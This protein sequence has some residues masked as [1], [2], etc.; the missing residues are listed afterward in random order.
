MKMHARDY[1]LGCGSLLTEPF[2]F[3][4]E[5]ERPQLRG[6]A[7]FLIPGDGPLETITHSQTPGESLPVF[8]LARFR[9]GILERIGRVLGL[10]SAPLVETEARRCFAGF[11]SG[12]GS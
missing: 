7:R 11:P 3:W 10:D 2:N 8:G 1:A 6:K 9:S 5:F 4:R 12:S